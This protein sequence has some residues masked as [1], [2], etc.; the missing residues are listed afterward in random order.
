VGVDEAPKDYSFGV[1][2]MYI[3]IDINTI[4]K[5]IKNKRT[6]DAL[7]LAV[8][9]KARYANSIVYK[10]SARDIK[11]ITHL[12][13]ERFSKC[14]KDGE[15]LGFF[16]YGNDTIKVNKLHI[17]NYRY[18]RVERNSSFKDIQNTLR[19]GIILNRV[20][21]IQFVKNIV[22]KADSPNYRFSKKELRQY[23]EVRGYVDYANKDLLGSIRKSS[24][25]RLVGMSKSSVTNLI[26]KM[27][28]KHLI[29]VEPMYITIGKVEGA[30]DIIRINAYR[31]SWFV[32]RRE[33]ELL[34]QIGNHYTPLVE[35]K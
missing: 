10:H 9:F 13:S 19:E 32:T 21:Q 4:E 5:C 28:E 20:N 31:D 27:K 22:V 34:Y 29:S 30:F 6:F 1:I 8:F 17:G 14:L 33:N 15:K 11:A 7:C 23:K 24:L 12:G 26:N 35:V 16:S 18:I 3:K 2:F 25:A